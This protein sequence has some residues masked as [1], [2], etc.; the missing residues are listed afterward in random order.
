MSMGYNVKLMVLQFVKP[1]VKTNKH[2]A[3][4]AICEAVTRPNKGGQF[5]P[6]FIA[7]LP[8]AACHISP[9]EIAIMY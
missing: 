5:F 7:D 2:D 9:S 3:A 8:L 6:K 4:D 1:Y